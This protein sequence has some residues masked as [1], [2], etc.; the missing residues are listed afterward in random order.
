MYLVDVR[1]LMNGGENCDHSG[2]AD[3]FA[4]TILCALY[5]KKTVSI[6]K[7]HSENTQLHEWSESDDSCEC[8]EATLTAAKNNTEWH[9]HPDL[10]S[11]CRYNYSRFTGVPWTDLCNKL[12][13][14]FELAQLVEKLQK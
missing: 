6:S 1:N 4:W 2:L 9:E 8:R 3:A 7:L 11:V 13:C 12:N 14:M 10:L 5:S